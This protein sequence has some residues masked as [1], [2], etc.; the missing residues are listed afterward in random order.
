MPRANA[1]ITLASSWMWWIQ[2]TCLPQQNAKTYIKAEVTHKAKKNQR[3]MI[4]DKIQ[5][6]NK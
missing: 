5:Q 6:K 4:T 1:F 3:E 2:R